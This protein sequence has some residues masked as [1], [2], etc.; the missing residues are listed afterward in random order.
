[1]KAYRT[2]STRK[3]SQTKPIIGKNMVANSGGGFAFTIDDWKRLDRF[4]VLGSAGGTYYVSERKLTKENAECVSHCIQL[5]GVR[6]V[7]RIV[8]ISDSGRAPKNDP[9][10]FALAMCAGLGN[11]ETK[12]AAFSALP[13]V[14]R[15]GTHLFHFASYVEQFRGWGRGLTNAVKNWYDSKPVEKLAYD[16]IKY[17]SRDG[18][19][20]RDLLRLAHPK[21][22]DMSRN[23]LYKW[24]VDTEVIDGLHEIVIA[25]ESAKKAQNAK[26]IVGLIAKNNLP[27]ECVPTQ[28]LNNAGVWDALLSKMPMEAMIRNLAKM[29]AV[30]LIR[31]LSGAMNTVISALDNADQIRKS[32]LHPFK[33]LTALKIYA[34]GCGE[35]GKLEWAPV[36]QIVDALNDAFY[37]AFE[38]VEPTGKRYVLGIDCSASMT[39]P[40]NNLSACGNMQ[41]RE[42]AAAM[43]LI[44]ASREKQHAIM[45]FSGSFVPLNISPRQRL[46]DVCNA[47][48]RIDAG[49]TNCSLPMLWAVEN[50]INADVFIVYTDN[51]TNY[52]GSIHPCQALQQYREKTG[53]P[54][55]LIVCGMTA[56][57]FSI[58]D[59][60][61]IGM[62]DIVGFD[63]ASPQ[64]ISDFVNE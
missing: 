26:E 25:F 49:N 42:G 61:D 21:T 38:N 50:K 23:V 31:P 10:L 5:D 14:A 59:D 43:A 3:T 7:N 13:K 30:G 54:A 16:A 56:T 60:S 19:A 27:R 28:F 58:A 32:R 47:I 53:I 9:A 64:L 2:V 39:W 22:D 40:E 17:Q 12:K 11:D 6:T 33:I 57:Q 41:A 35:K 8:E 24:I 52:H 29:T 48:G 18:W 34:Q 55:K 1:M 20:H 15:I 63:T 37:A 44:T 45:G 62:L 51:E 36:S 4:L 46:D